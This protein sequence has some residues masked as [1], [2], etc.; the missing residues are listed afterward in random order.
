MTRCVNS[1]GL[2]VRGTCT[3]LRPSDTQ[4]PQSSSNLPINTYRIPHRVK[5][6]ELMTRLQW[7]VWAAGEREAVCVYV[8]EEEDRCR[9]KVT[10]T[11]SPYLV[12]PTH[13][14]CCLSLYY[15]SPQCS[16]THTGMTHRRPYKFGHQLPTEKYLR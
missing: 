3:C 1:G 9:R 14:T 12:P 2:Q 10:H 16:S 5:V 13:C 4:P 15:P 8:G 6:R 11:V 7:S